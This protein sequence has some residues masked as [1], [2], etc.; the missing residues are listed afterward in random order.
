MIGCAGEADTY[1]PSPVAASSTFQER[2]AA[3]TLANVPRRKCAA[4]NEDLHL[5]E[6]LAGMTLSALLTGL[7]ISWLQTQPIA[8]I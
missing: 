8:A 3:C 6:I 1:G 4:M 7:A 5:W 2:N